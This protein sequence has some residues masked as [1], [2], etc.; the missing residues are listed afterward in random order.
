MRGRGLPT[1]S[2]G[3][4][5]HWGEGMANTSAAE[6]VAA[7]TAILR[8]G[9]VNFYMAH[10]GS[11]WGFWAGQCAFLGRCLIPA[12]SWPLL[13]QRQGRFG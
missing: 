8:Y 1:C 5:T 2:T 4:I 11:N 12:G 9:S 13:S 7:L 10:G 6:L 3:W